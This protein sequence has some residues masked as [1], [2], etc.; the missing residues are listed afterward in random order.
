MCHRLVH[1]D[2]PLAPPSSNQS[3][4][5]LR[6]TGRS[7]NRTTNSESIRQHGEGHVCPHDD[8][9]LA[10]ED[11]S[12]SPDSGNHSPPWLTLCHRQ[13]TSGQQQHPDLPLCLSHCRTRHPSR[14]DGNHHVHP[15]Q[16]DMN[17]PDHASR[18]A[19]TVLT[20]CSAARCMPQRQTTPLGTCTWST[21]KSTNHNGGICRESP[22]R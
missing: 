3:R 9:S 11:A 5:H 22:F 10:N 4:K 21:G 16:P 17:D 12:G 15:E 13:C 20:A 2:P 6:S 8:G 7:N 14:I 18:P 19:A 1:K